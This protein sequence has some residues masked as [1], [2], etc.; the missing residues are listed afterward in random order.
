MNILMFRDLVSSYIQSTI[1]GYLTGLFLD[2][3]G[4]I[5]SYIH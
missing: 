1:F 3:K 2:P 5:K 4:T